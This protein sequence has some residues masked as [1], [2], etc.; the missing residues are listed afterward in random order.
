M[1]SHR[2]SSVNGGIYVS[3]DKKKEKIYFARINRHN[4][5]KRGIMVGI[6]MLAEQYS[7]DRINNNG[8]GLLIDCGANAGELGLWSRK[9]SFEYIAFE[10]EELESKCVNLNAKPGSKTFRNALW[11]EKARLTIHS[12]PNSGDSSVFDM[13]DA[14]DKFE[15]DA[16]RLDETVSLDAYDGVV[17][18]KVEAEGAEPEV[19]EG[20][21]GLFDR[22][23]YIAV[24]CGPERGVEQDYTFVEVNNL[25]VDNNFRL[26]DVK[27]DR[28]TSLYY[29]KER[30]SGMLKDK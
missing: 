7:L 21:S 26:C 19:L 22:I 29:N 27:F 11:K 3:I 8:K 28:V 30:V 18:L 23:D 17:I 20:A 14:V 9:N 1:K 16:V 15:I 5:Y 12:M 24:D 6:D 2:V 4:R 25:L 13:G 10:P